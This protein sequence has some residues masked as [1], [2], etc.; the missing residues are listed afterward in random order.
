VEQRP[1]AALVAVHPVV[2]C[3]VV[4]CTVVGDLEQVDLLGLEVYIITHPMGLLGEAQLAILLDSRY[5]QIIPI[6]L[7]LMEPILIHRR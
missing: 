1:A 4:A 2:A 3:T 5:S 7:G 6:S